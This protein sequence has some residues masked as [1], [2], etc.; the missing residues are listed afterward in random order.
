MHNLLLAGAALLF[1]AFLL[2]DG[3]RVGPLR[4]TVRE[5]LASP[6]GADEELEA[7]LDQLRQGAKSGPVLAKIKDRVGRE[8]A[9]EKRAVWLCGAGHVLRNTLSRKATAIRYY[10]SALKADPACREARLAL[11]DVLLAQRRGFALEQLYWKLLARLDPEQH[12][13]AVVREVWAE[14]ADVLERR[15]SGRTRAQALRFLLD[16][17]EQSSS[18]SSRPPSPD[19]S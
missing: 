15:R 4:K 8:E 9:P 7:L 13:D 16:H 3:L 18:R 19:P 12:G 11:R 5:R 10:K 6:P 2:W 1:V 17:L 14:L